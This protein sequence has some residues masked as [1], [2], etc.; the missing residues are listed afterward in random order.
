MNNWFLVGTPEPDNPYLKVTLATYEAP[1]GEDFGRFLASWP[2]D[3]VFEYEH[4]KY[5]TILCLPANDEYECTPPLFDKNMI[6]GRF[7]LCMRKDNQFVGFHCQDC[8]DYVTRW[9]MEMQDY[10]KATHYA[11]WYRIDGPLK[12]ANTPIY[13]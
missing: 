4:E 12:A 1:E 11:D 2:G 7:I 13:H 9:F 5:G 3:R 6:F 10:W 8:C